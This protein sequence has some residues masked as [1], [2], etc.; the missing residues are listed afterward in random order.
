ME[1]ARVHAYL[2]DADAGNGAGEEATP[3]HVANVSSQKQEPH[4]MTPDQQQAREDSPSLSEK[5]CPTCGG[6]GYLLEDNGGD[7]GPLHPL[8]AQQVDCWHC[9]G[10]GRIPKRTRKAKTP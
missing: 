5:W 1:A 7:G 9:K 3:S 4:P 10:S 2:L 6:H 8:Y